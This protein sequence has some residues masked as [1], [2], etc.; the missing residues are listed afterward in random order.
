MP[1]GREDPKPG[2]RLD[3]FLKNAGILKRRSMARTYCESGAVSVNGRSARSGKQ[4]HAGDRVRL[5]TWNRRLELLVRFIPRKGGKQNQ[6]CCQ[7][8]QD[9]R[10]PQEE[11]R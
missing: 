10:K 8:L 4:V 11:P 9:E 6:E 5:D 7:I 2:I 3:A 1:S